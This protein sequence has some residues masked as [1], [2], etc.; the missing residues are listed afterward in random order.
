M[1]AEPADKPYTSPVV[2]FTDARE[3]EAVVQDPPVTVLDRRIEEATHTEVSP[4]MVPAEAEPLT[5]MA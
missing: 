3:V 4:L 1:L 2:L 5:K